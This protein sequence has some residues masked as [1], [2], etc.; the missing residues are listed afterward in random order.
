MQRSKANKN[1]TTTI[2]L[3]II[4][5]RSLTSYASGISYTMSTIRS[6]N[7]F[8]SMISS[9]EAKY[10]EGPTTKK[11]KKKTTSEPTEEEFIFAQQRMMKK[12]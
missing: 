2:T 12:K 1:K 8:D 7:N 9:L 11:A 6:Q 4:V 3:F 5:G 10:A